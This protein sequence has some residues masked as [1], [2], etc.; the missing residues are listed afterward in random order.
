MRLYHFEKCQHLH[1][2]FSFHPFSL[3]RIVDLLEAVYNTA[4]VSVLCGVVSDRILVIASSSSWVLLYIHPNYQKSGGRGLIR[5]SKVHE[6]GP[7]KTLIR[8]ILLFFFLNLFTWILESLF[9]RHFF[10]PHF[11]FIVVD[12]VFFWT[13]RFFSYQ[14]HL[15][16]LTERLPSSSLLCPSIFQFLSCVHRNAATEWPD[17][18][19]RAHPFPS[20]R[21]FCLTTTTKR[22]EEKIWSQ[23][24]MYNNNKKKTPRNSR[25]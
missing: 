21:L 20:N 9:F 24:K 4:I 13:F 23:G 7:S 17:N 1:L 2:F 11:L 16:K 19:A 22:K 10:A 15:S 25:K 14:C 5:L 3:P 18:P 6:L 8:I 12:L